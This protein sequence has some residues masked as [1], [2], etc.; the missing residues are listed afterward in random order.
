M[1]HRSCFS[2]GTGD[3]K[4]PHAAVH[5][6]EQ[7]HGMAC[8]YSYGLSHAASH[9]LALTYLGIRVIFN[10]KAGL[11]VLTIVTTVIWL[12]CCLCCLGVFL[13]LRASP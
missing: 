2:D 13:G 10:I 4:R 8:N 12:A 5:S 6:A 1:M 9:S 3:D 11:R 7:Q